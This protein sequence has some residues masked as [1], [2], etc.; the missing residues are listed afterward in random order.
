MNINVKY[1]LI[2]IFGLEQLFDRG[3]DRNSCLG[4]E[5]ND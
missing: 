5:N 3:G 1:E 2:L 4:L